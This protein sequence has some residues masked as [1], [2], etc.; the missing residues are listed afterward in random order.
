MMHARILGTGPGVGALIEVN[1][2]PRIAIAE[3]L[4]NFLNATGDTVLGLGNSPVF[5]ET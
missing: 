2:A 5:H 3:C 1:L 4:A